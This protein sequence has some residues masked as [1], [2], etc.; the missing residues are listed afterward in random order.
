METSSLWDEI[1]MQCTTI[2]GFRMS[3]SAGEVDFWHISL[4]GL[5]IVMMIPSHEA[6]AAAGSS[7]TTFAT[8]VQLGASSVVF[9]IALSPGNS[10]K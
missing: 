10:G 6:H 9:S 4:L 1:L 5:T 7:I 2:T 8:Q 3:T